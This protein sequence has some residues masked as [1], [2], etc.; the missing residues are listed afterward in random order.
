MDAPSPKSMGYTQIMQTTTNLTNDPTF[1]CSDVWGNWWSVPAIRSK[2]LD[3]FERIVI[4]GLFGS[5]FQALVVSI[6]TALRF[7]QSIVI[8]DF[9]VLLT[10]TMMVVMVLL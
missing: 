8:S 5:F 6:G 10:E 4:L 9:M 2:V 3:A 7:G 1:A